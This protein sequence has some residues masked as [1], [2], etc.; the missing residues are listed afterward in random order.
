MAVDGDASPCRWAAVINKEP[1]CE[2][3]LVDLP[4][5]EQKA[6][7]QEL[8]RLLMEPQTPCKAQTQHLPASQDTKLPTK[9]EVRVRNTFV[10]LVG[11]SSRGIIH[12]SKSDS[13]LIN[14]KV[15]RSH[16][17][18]ASNQ[19]VIDENSDS[20]SMQQQALSPEKGLGRER[21]NKKIY[22]DEAQIPEVLN[23]DACL[24]TSQCHDVNERSPDLSEASTD[25][26]RESL[27]DLSSYE[28]FDPTFMCELVPQ[29]AAD[30][31]GD[32]P[33]DCSMYPVHDSYQQSQIGTDYISSD[34]HQSDGGS[35]NEL[36]GSC[37]MSEGV[38]IG[39]SQWSLGLLEEEVT[40]ASISMQQEMVASPD[41]C[42]QDV[43]YMPMQQQFIPTKS[44]QEAWSVWPQ[45]GDC[46]ASSSWATVNSNASDQFCM[47]NAYSPS[48]Y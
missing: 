46:V 36:S 40:N 18:S 7:G 15:E 27:E 4:L 43:V 12:R 29:D 32:Q 20:L 31:F 37:F 25:T 21:A 5:N 47:S 24:P 45:T 38:V 26:P 16:Q 19:N 8:M 33:T 48:W 30:V 14:G 41:T 9:V 44:V 39:V 42:H 28:T 13:E 23:L 1:E 3:Q 17:P 11:T 2:R 34:S 10:D 35:L 22:Q 6:R